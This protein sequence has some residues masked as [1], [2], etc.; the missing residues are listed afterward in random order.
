MK[1][2]YF[3]NCRIHCA[4]SECDFLIATTINE[5]KKN[6]Q[7]VCSKCSTVITVDVEKVI[8]RHKT[9]MERLNHLAARN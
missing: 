5:L 1:N 7:F 8:E 9:M 3:D 6:N 2:L 4:N